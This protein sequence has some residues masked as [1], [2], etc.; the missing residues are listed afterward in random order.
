MVTWV[1]KSF[2]FVKQGGYLDK[3][4][5]IYPAPPLTPRSL[6]KSEYDKIKEAFKKDDFNLLKALLEIKKFPFNDPYI[7][8][9]RI[10]PEEI[11]NNPLTVK[12]IAVRLREMGLNGVVAGLVEP[13]QFNRQ[14]G[15][16]FSKWIKTKYVCAHA[17]EE[18]IKRS[19]D[20]LFFDVSG[21]KLRL[22]ANE[23]GCGI[24]KQPDFIAKTKGRYILG[25]AKFLGT[26]GGNQNRAFED[27]IKLASSSFK[28][29]VTVA[30]IDGIAWIPDSGQM[31]KRLGNFSGNA[32]TALLLDEFLNSL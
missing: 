23:Q 17:P 4:A 25:E 24:Q 14:M 9:L 3:L 19:E 2:S 22:F 5:E 10:M 32:L 13:K 29:A 30:V 18:F 12:R 27:A 26:E 11:N 20:I 16:M 7:G 6:N 21:E 28:N 15:A 1:E 31:S 8:F